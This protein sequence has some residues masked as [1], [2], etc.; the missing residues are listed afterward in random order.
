M[1]NPLD[2]AIANQARPDFSARYN[3]PLSPEEMAKFVAWAQAEA[4]NRGGRDPRGDIV[5]YDIQGFW[6]GRQGFDER[7]HGTD[8]Y[9]KPNHPTFSTGSQYAT[10]PGMQP[11]DWR[12]SPGGM[13]TFVAGPSNLVYQTPA[14][15]RQYFREVEPGVG[16]R[17]PSAPPLERLQSF[18][19]PLIDAAS[20]KLGKK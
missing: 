8:V 13:T 6:K 11:G 19:M 12:E 9:K 5:D 7:G 1:P 4:A 15:L 2:E 3:T 10:L 20:R 14:Q 18:L 16:L 17:T